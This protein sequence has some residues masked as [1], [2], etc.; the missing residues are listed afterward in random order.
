MGGANRRYRHPSRRQ[1]MRKWTS[2]KV[3]EIAVGMEINCY[4]CATA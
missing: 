1:S 4:A 3:V 2:P